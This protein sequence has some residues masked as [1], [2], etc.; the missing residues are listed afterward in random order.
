MSY[1]QYLMQTRALARTGARFVAARSDC[2]DE[3]L[4]RA[5]DLIKTIS[6]SC[7]PAVDGIVERAPGVAPLDVGAISSPP[8]RY[9]FSNSDAPSPYPMS[10]S[11]LVW[12]ETRS[13][14][15]ST[16]LPP[17]L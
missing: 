7:Q 15:T 13:T 2:S 17:H 14:F 6:L 3:C 9:R 12:V 10:C 11:A 4:F 1:F 5:L 16:T 8:P